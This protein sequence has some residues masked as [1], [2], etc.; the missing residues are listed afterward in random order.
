MGT[1]ATADFVSQYSIRD[2]ENL[3]GIKAHTI[4]IWEQRYGL[5]KPKRTST[6]IRYYDAVDLKLIL[7]VARLKE[8]GHKISKIASMTADDM[9][10]HLEALENGAE[11]QI[12]RFIHSLTTAMIDLDEELF[13]QTLSTAILQLGL[14]STM[15]EII[16]PFLIKIGHLWQ[17]EAI[18]P[19]QEHFISCLLRQK[20]IVAIDGQ[21]HNKHENSKR[22]ILYLP[23]GELHEI[24]LLFSCYLVKKEGH[25][26]IYLGQNMPLTDVVTTYNLYKPDYVLCIST[27]SPERNLMQ[28]YIN[29][30]SD[31]LPASTVLMSGYAVLSADLRVPQ[32]VKLLHTF[33]ELDDYLA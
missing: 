3:S 15:Y 29:D 13:E 1:A 6:N 18:N 22:F 24:S 2:L 10:D 16:H 27:S 20:L 28:K 11:D 33:N 23:E 25:Q 26:V 30:L 4:R 17:T 12:G 8:N 31:N 21:K 9:N 14:D 19:A 32:N 7:K 5:V